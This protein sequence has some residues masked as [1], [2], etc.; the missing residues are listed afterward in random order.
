MPSTT[1]SGTALTRVATTGSPASI[2]SSSTIPKPSQRDESTKT[3]AR[4]SQSRI[5]VRPGSVT[6]PPKP[7]LFHESARLLAR[8]GPYP[9]S[10]AALPAAS[11]RTSANARSS[12][13]WSFCS[14]SRPTAG[15]SGGGRWNAGLRRRR[16]GPRRG[17]LVE[18][19][20][21]RRRARSVVPGLLEE[22]ANGVGDRDQRPRAAR[23]R[24]VDVPE[25]AEQVAVVVVAGRDGRTPE[26]AQAGDRAVH[27]RVDEMWSCSEVRLLRADGRGSRRAPSAG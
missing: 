6:A 14:I 24:A 11:R 26:V 15:A 23:E 5:S 16:L 20:V 9:G 4:S 13:A 21:D 17:Q 27:V 7:E 25:R 1:I 2:A 3:S 12:V 19:V 18:P 22:A 8:A 10:P